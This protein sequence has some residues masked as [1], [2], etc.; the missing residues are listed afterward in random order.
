MNAVA[1]RSAVLWTGGKD[2]AMA[3]YE[4]GRMG[5]AI[6][7][8]VTFA[9]AGARFLAHPLTMMKMQSEALTLPHRVFTVVEPFEDGYEA[10]LRQLK[11][12]LGIDRVVTGDIT[13][14]EGRPNWIRERSRPVGMNVHT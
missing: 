4:A 1:P 2:S 12:E 6:C 7:C 13:E 10:A 5:Y 11:D 9:P 8:L 3:L 14:V